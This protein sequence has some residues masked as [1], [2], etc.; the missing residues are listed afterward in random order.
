[1]ILDE[2]IVFVS[3]LKLI[4][5]GAGSEQD[6]VD[7]LEAIMRCSSE[8]GKSLAT[9]SVVEFMEAEVGETAGA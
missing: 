8:E 5:L 7:D 1:M 3:I 9:E 6:A 2:K 4:F